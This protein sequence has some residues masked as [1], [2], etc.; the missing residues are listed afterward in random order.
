MDEKQ[1]CIHFFTEDGQYITEANLTNPPPG[2]ETDWHLNDQW[3][4][5]VD[6]IAP[7][8]YGEGPDVWKVILRAK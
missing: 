5:T 1:A 3:W 4:L 7:S 8:Q 2:V 6:I